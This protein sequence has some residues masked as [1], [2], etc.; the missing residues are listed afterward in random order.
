MSLSPEWSAHFLALFDAVPDGLLI[1]NAEGTVA[2]SNS[3]AQRLFG[4]TFEALQGLSV[5]LLLPERFRGRHVAL[6]EGYT[7]QPTVRPMGA[8]GITLFGLRRDGTEVPVD[9]S[10]SPLELDGRRVTIVAVRDSSAREASTRRFRELLEAAP[11]AMVITDEAGVI[12]LV[13]A[14]AEKL[15]GYRRD[16]LL[17]QR[18]EVLLPERLRAHHP[19]RRDD[20]MRAPRPRAMGET[21]AELFGRRADGSEFLA[22]I[23]LSPLETERGLLVMSSVRDVTASR[24][25]QQRLRKSEKDLATTLDSIA[26]AL[27]VTDVQGRI[28]RMNPVARRLTGVGLAEALERPVEEVVRLVHPESRAELPHPVWEALREGRT[29][30]ASNDALL[31]SREGRAIPVAHTATPIQDGGPPLGAILVFR[32]VTGEHEAKKARARLEVADRMASVGTLAAGVAHEINNPLAY[33][34]SNLAFLEEQLLELRKAKGL[35]RAS[36]GE[37]DEVLRDAKEG[38]E[39][40]RRI[41]RDLKTFSRADSEAH[42]PTDVVAVLESAA[43]MA[44]NEIRH[45]AQLLKDLQPVPPV[46]G[47]AGRL[48]Q[49]FL[50]LLVN[51]AQAIKEGEARGNR[52]TIATAATPRGTVEVRISDTGGGIAP[53]HL[54]RIFDPFFTTKPVGVGTGLGLSISHNIVTSMGGSVRVESEVGRGTTFTVELQAAPE[55]DAEAQAP[56]VAAGASGP[57]GRVLLIDDEER[58]L[59]ATRRVLQAT[60]HEVVALVRGAEALERI[61]GGERFDVILCDLMMPD[62]TGE[63]VHAELSRIAPDQADRMVFLTGG[64]FTSGAKAFLERMPGRVLEKPFE[65]A[66]VRRVVE[67]WID[68]SRRGGPS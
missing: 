24:E 16:E 52:I 42:G 37:V 20:Y 35:E 21:G 47:D 34:V 63:D 43:N 3:N 36:F 60:G 17:G 61:R 27:I 12:T 23:S 59:T 62:I 10:L 56:V 38:A 41:V 44:F 32:D 15:F 26:D 11:D 48:G 67:E 25:L 57:A 14:Q 39:R 53:E 9:I 40:I 49:V 8:P 55:A 33:V 65:N 64:A 2:L 31:L 13:N 30:V 68:R 54:K 66:A 58:V 45:R 4:Y 28:S 51:A 19:D 5:E 50:N 6:R 46:A 22:E 1:V 29:V 18:V 7:A